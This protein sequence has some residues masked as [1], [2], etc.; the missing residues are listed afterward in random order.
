MQD[1]KFKYSIYKENN[2]NKAT[3]TGYVEAPGDTLKLPATVDY[4]AETY[5]VTAIGNN[6]FSG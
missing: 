1:S 5:K 6:V 3:I 4:Q 2:E